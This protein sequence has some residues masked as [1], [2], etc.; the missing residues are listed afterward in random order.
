MPR[1]ALGIEHKRARKARN[2]R[3]YH[4][5]KAAQAEGSIVHKV[6]ACRANMPSNVPAPP[7]LP[8][9][10]VGV[11]LKMYFDVPQTLSYFEDIKSSSSSFTPTGDS[12]ARMVPVKSAALFV[13]PSMP[14]LAHPVVQSLVGLNPST[15][16]TTATS[17]PVFL[18][19]AQNAHLADRGALTGESSPLQLKQ[20]GVS[21]VELG[22][23]ERRAWPFNEDDSFI[24]EK[25][26][27][28]VRNGLIPL[29]CVGEVEREQGSKG[30]ER[31]VEECREQVLRPLQAVV[32]AP[33]HQS[34]G[35][36][37][38][39]PGVVFAYEPVWAIGASEPASADHVVAVIAALRECIRVQA[40]WFQGSLR[41]LYGG[42][43]GPGT[44]EKLEHECDGLFL[45]RF[46]HDV[47]NLT[48][49]WGEVV[50]T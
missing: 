45:G 49:V 11:S 19:G 12:S 15:T 27:G 42:S 8:D 47:A 46:A 4:A 41:F 21:I 3:A 32:E 9:R 40:P 26:R 30:V 18:L 33:D 50:G 36:H 29:V 23:V 1:L 43:A 6:R 13:V 14:L 37:H 38:R 20:L 25:V 35:L 2:L 34:G 22:H 31:A 17:Q 24:K 10:L 48:R 44:W 7:D 28:A 39:H 16:T 5:R